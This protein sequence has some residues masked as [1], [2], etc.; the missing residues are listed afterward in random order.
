MQS[1]QHLTTGKT[2][3][4][5]GQDTHTQTE[6]KELNGKQTYHKENKEIIDV[7]HHGLYYINKKKQMPYHII[8]SQFRINF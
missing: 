6:D 2:L 4:G 1:P 3:E 7:L 8:S 5:M